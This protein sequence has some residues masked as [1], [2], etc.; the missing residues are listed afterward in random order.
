MLSV[1]YFGQEIHRDSPAPRFD[2][3]LMREMLFTSFMMVA[4]R[5][6]ATNGYF[7]FGFKRN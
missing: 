6:G 7:S 1:S 5:I 2:Y 4:K 3:K